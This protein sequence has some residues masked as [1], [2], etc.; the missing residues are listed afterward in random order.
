[1]IRLF[2]G[3]DDEF[4]K[5]ASISFGI[6]FDHAKYEL[7][8]KFLGEIVQHKDLVS[9]VFFFIPGAL[10]RVWVALQETTFALRMKTRVLFCFLR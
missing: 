9:E 5:K 3:R 6:Q 10:L 2:I 8:K 1:M 4:R 7:L